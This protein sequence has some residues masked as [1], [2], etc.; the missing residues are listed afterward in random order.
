[1]PYH[2]DFRYT[3]VESNGLRTQGV[4]LRSQ[5]KIRASLPQ[6]GIPMG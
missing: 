6:R 5:L 4:I 1:M 3:T 2:Q